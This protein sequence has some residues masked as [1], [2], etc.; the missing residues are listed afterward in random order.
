[1]IE[2]K[3]TPLS[4]KDIRRFANQVRRRF[5]LD[6]TKAVDVLWLLEEVFPTIFAGVDFHIDVLPKEEMG[7]MHGFTTINNNTIYIREDVYN[8]AARGKG[9]DRMTIAHEIGHYLMHDGI[10]VGLARRS[11]GESIVRY[12]DPEWQA[13]VF[14]AELL[15]PAEQIRHMT[16]QEIVNTYGVSAQAAEFQLGIV[17]K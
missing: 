17:G 7:D 13:K 15:M 8:N 12:R 10:M 14:A 16:V 3:A 4:R 6:P 11:D 2:F 9:R 5:H 1:M